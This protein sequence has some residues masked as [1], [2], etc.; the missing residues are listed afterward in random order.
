MVAVRLEASLAAIESH[1]IETNKPH[2]D[3]LDQ[4][5]DR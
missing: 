3:L 4:S 1:I 5:K 2:L